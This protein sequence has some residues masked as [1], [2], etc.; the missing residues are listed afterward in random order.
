MVSRDTNSGT[1]ETFHKMVMK[2]QKIFNACE[3]VGS[4]GA[5]K[6]RVQ[7]TPNAI[8]YAGLGFVDRTVKPIETQ[9]KA[10]HDD[11]KLLLAKGGKR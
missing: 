5:V 3:Y 4:N 7:N 2:K 11:I 9:I 6:G 1:Y 8:G 10:V